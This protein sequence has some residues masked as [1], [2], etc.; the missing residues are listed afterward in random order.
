MR[1]DDW[2][3]ERSD[4]SPGSGRGR[5]W[6]QRGT[7]MMLGVV[8]GAGAAFSADIWDAIRSAVPNSAIAMAPEPAAKS[9][10]VPGRSDT[11]DAIRQ[12]H[13]ALLA[14]ARE[15]IGRGELQ[16]AERLIGA[17]EKLDPDAPM[18]ADARRQ[19]DVAK[20]KLDLARSAPA[21]G[22]TDAPVRPPES[23][24][25]PAQAPE[26]TTPAGAVPSV[27]FAEG[28]KQFRARNYT[29]ALALLGDAAAAGH[30]PAQNYLGYMYRHGFGVNQDFA[31]ALS[32]YRKAA[33]QG[34]GG[35]MNN[36]GY[37]YRHGLGVE[38]NDA[39]ALGWFRR[40]AERGDA[41]GQYNLG[42]MLTDG[43]G[44][45]ADHREAFKWLRAAADQGHPRA[46][47]SLGHMYAQG[48]GV[49]AEQAEAYFWYGIAARNGVEGAQ[50]FRT[51]LGTQ[52]TNTQRQVADAR[53]ARWRTQD[54][55]GEA[56]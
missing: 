46:A 1:K 11:A 24:K 39:D 32:W 4:L 15:A 41:S 34:H 28:V 30:A 36:I 16:E 7:G 54:A 37:L 40:A 43:I 44:V 53:V 8:A 29:G 22:R 14:R 13:H 3:E 31:R 52:L 2:D 12:L 51:A 50:R 10:A 18:I 49:A 38:R 55:L 5:Q 17:A 19:L 56:Q 6:L 26:A 23:A 47:F 35:A 21:T 42:Q 45:A 20:A 48:L 25:T 27:A 9:A 33:D